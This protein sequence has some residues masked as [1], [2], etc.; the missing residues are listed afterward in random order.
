[1][2]RS[3]VAGQE[4]TL[5]GNDKL[6]LVAVGSLGRLLSRIGRNDEASSLQC[7]VYAQLLKANGAEDVATMTPALDFGRALGKLGQHARAADVLKQTLSSQ[8][9]ILGHTH[10]LTALTTRALERVYHG[11]EMFAELELLQAD[12][13][14]AKRHDLGEYHKDT[15]D[16]AARLSMTY[17]KL[18][19]SAEANN[20][21]RTSTIGK[22]VDDLRKQG[23]HSEAAAATAL[24]RAGCFDG[25]IIEETLAGIKNGRPA[26]A[27]SFP[28]G[29]IDG[30]IVLMETSMV[31]VPVSE[32]EEFKKSE[33]FKN[34]EE[35][36]KRVPS[37]GRFL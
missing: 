16:A 8:R 29:D 7:R 10:H 17:L 11:Q 25:P 20:L 24:A 22:C 4:K 6:T 14:E 32:L 15:L 36:K 13:Y 28:T 30:N 19:R 21:I 26:T 2:C 12:V 23:K 18:G 27:P 35:L 1:M 9:H 31:L 5:G 3:V 33:M 34:S 37:L